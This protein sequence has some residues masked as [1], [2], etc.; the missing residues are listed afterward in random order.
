MRHLF[1]C[2]AL[3]GASL[4]AGAQLGQTTTQW[5]RLLDASAP[6]MGIA[7]T[8]SGQSLYYLSCTGTSVGPGDSGAVKEYDDPTA[9]VY[10][11]GECIATGAPYE[12]ASYNNNFSLVKTALDGTFS[13]TVY[14]TS[15]DFAS[16]HGGVVPAPDGGVYVSTVVRHTDNLRTQP[17]VLVDASGHEHAIDW[18]L[19]DAEAKRWQQGLLLKVSAQGAIEWTK[20]VTVSHAPVPAATGDHAEGTSAACYISGMASDKQGN[21]Y[22]SG[23]YVTPITIDGTT[24]TPHNTEGWN[25]DS[26]QTRGDVFIAKFDAQ[27]QLL[28]TLT[29]G[30]EARVE[31]NAVLTIA[32]GDLWLAMTAT[33][34]GDNACAITLDGHQV[35]LP[36]DQQCVALARLDTDL[37]V[38]W[39]QQWRGG[40]VQNRDAVMQNMRLT[41][42]GDHL[43][44]TGQCNGSYTN[45]SH[46]VA[47]AT[48]NVREGIL[49]K[50]D[51]ATG[52]WLAATTS[53]AAFPTMKNG[54]QGY[55]G[56]FVGAGGEQVCVFGETFGG[57][58]ITLMRFDAGTLAG[59]ECVTLIAGGSM[60][61]AQQCLATD[62]TLYTLT[63]G[64]D[65]H[66]PAYQL[67]PIGSDLSLA[68]QD[69]AVCMAAFTLPFA[70]MEE[71][72]HEAAPGDINGDGVADVDDLNIVINI[73]L[74]KLQDPATERQADL[75]GNGVVDISDVN[76]IINAI[77]HKG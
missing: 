2:A 60:P 40:Q 53:K 64:R 22:V 52:E 47:T 46:I 66:L 6:D 29:T 54:I 12:G 39:L 33:G 42:A 57:E 75:D 76:A 45:G 7:F 77:L 70:V 11:G 68:T 25:G 35:A 34:T 58:G 74:H 59:E 65:S 9:S 32:Q 15:G 73:I 51:A 36:D 67:Q 62:N 26:Q 55:K 3:L 24:L 63:R 49:V 43:W 8:E 23:R 4:T 61:T 10:Y 1:I 50:C 13:W 30:G 48:G 14:S 17:I 69:W 18:T 21:F 44:F 28:A 19:P 56:C 41:V 38:K 31:S 72:T 27:G 20:L 5:A 37:R 71:G 16:G